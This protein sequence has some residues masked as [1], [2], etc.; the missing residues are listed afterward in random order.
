MIKDPEGAS[1]P[2][3]GKDEKGDKKKKKKK[4]KKGSGLTLSCALWAIV[5]PTL[6]NKVVEKQVED[7]KKSGQGTSE[8]VKELNAQVIEFIKKHC[9]APLET[10]YKDSKSMI[11]IADG[12]KISDKDLAKSF[13]AMT[14]IG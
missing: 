12:K 8:Q 5:Y 6:L 2:K 11:V 9:S 3:E 14:V 7:K 10:F 1:S 4:D 13:T